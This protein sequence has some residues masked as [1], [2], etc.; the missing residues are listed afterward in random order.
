MAYGR[1]KRFRGAR[2]HARNGSPNHNLFA[3]FTHVF[4]LTTGPWI[5]VPG[6]PSW[7]AFITSLPSSRLGSYGFRPPF[8]QNS[9]RSGS[10]PPS[11]RDVM[12]CHQ[13]QSLLQYRPARQRLER[14]RTALP[15]ACS[16]FRPR[17]C[18]DWSAW[19]DGNTNRFPA[20]FKI[21]RS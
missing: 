13:N 3:Q 4:S 19:L 15:F 16:L 11:S 12:E 21:Q 20:L 14:G 9:S 18:P 17:S 7:I 5:N 8:L 10:L 1:D 6:L 2:P